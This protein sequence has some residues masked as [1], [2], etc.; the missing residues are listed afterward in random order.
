MEHPITIAVD[1]DGTEQGPGVAIEGS[2]IALE[3][4]EHLA[5]QLIG[6]EDSIENAF[7]T[8]P[9]QFKLQQH[10]NRIT[11]VFSTDVILM[12]DT[13]TDALRDKKRSA[14]HLGIAMQASGE[15]DGFVSAGNTGAV[16]AISMRML[17]R[18]SGVSRPAI[19][20]VL[21]SLVGPSLVLDVGANADCRPIYLRDY[22]LMGAVYAKDVL[23][24]HN[25]PVALV[26][27]G[28]EPS[29]GSELYQEAYQLLLQETEA[30]SPLNFVGNNE[31]GDILKGVTRVFVLDGQTGNMM[32]KF[33]ENVLPVLNDGLKKD[34]GNGRFDQKVFA[35][36]GKH[37]LGPTL[38][39]VKRRFNYETYGG[40]PLLGV[41]GNI[42]IAHGNSSV[43]AMA[44]AVRQ[45]YDAASQGVH[46][47]IKKRFSSS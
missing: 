36:I 41:N 18:I 14:I 12:H 30:Q 34:I 47:H 2:I 42:V 27:M 16:L 37:L 29:K 44:S 6:Q 39:A 11:K 45:A 7:S 31:G 26:N 10:N 9:W 4:C 28:T 3:N 32:L 25:P 33:I 17:K 1:V 35:F 38:G 46:L 43:A 13:P 15:S 19:A 22:A 23:H 24:I 5:I 21:P 40:A 8:E 20:S